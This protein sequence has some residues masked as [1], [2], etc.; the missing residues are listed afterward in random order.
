MFSNQRLCHTFSPCWIATAASTRA[1]IQIYPTCTLYTVFR[2][3]TPPDRSRRT[4]TDRSRCADRTGSIILGGWEANTAAWIAPAAS[5]RA[6]IRT[7]PTFTLD[8]VSQFTTPTD[9]S[10]R[11][12]TT[13]RSRSTPTDR[14]RSTDRTGSSICG[15]W[16]TDPVAWIA[17]AAKAGT[18]LKPFFTRFVNLL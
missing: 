2:F 12:P 6:T 1:T 16:E 3:T 10:R 15:G 11:N 5:I 18:T 8:I 13:D 9:R 4:P 14:S 17:P 7:Y